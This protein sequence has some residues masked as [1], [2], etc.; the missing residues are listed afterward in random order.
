ML[1]HYL[2]IFPLRETG[3]PGIKTVEEEAE[4]NGLC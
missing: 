1:G 3:Q 4:G 2:G